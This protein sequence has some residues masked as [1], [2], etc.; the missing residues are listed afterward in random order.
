M[1]NIALNNKRLWISIVALIIPILLLSKGI[2]GSFIFTFSI[3]II[4]QV[5]FLGKSID[6]LGLKIHSITSSILAGIVSGCL[7]GFFGGSLL[8]YLGITGYFYNAAHKL[9]VSVGSF[10]I[11]FPLQKEFGYRLLNISNSAVGV[12]IYFL[13]CILVIGLG[14]EIFWRGF[15][16]KKL[17]SY[18]SPHKSIWVAAILFAMIHFYIFIILPIKTGISFLVLIAL[19]GGIWGYLFK[20]FDNIWSS[21]VSHGVVAFIIWKYYFFSH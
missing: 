4:W 9:Q 16:Q 11:A 14:E 7:V 20:Y 19:V 8:K 13:F 5:G 3:P 12:C 2:Y 17:S 10:N 21:A 1:R 6:S 15:V 18:L